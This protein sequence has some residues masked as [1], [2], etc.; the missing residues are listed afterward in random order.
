MDT[1]AYRQVVLNRVG[2]VLRPLGFRK[3]GLFFERRLTDVV[4]FVSL[5][6]STISTALSLKLTVN[7]GVLIPELLE[8]WEKADVW[9][10][11][12]NQRLG[13]LMPNPED[14]WWTIES[15]SEAGDVAEVLAEAIR[16]FA[17]PSLDKL[18]GRNEIVQLWRGGSSPGITDAQRKRYLEALSSA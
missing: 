6:A 3:R 5:Q 1:A 7:V 16:V 2:L 17:V 11:Q 13:F 10:C 9:S 4:Q 14:R 12:W 8:T 18:I 15:S